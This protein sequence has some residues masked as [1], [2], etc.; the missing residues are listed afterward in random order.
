MIQV[1]TTNSLDPLGMKRISKEDMRTSV[2][3]AWRSDEQFLNRFFSSIKKPILFI[4]VGLN[5]TKLISEVIHLIHF[6]K[7]R[8]F[9]HHQKFSKILL[10]PDHY[11]AIETDT[12]DDFVNSIGGRDVPIDS[13]V[14]LYMGDVDSHLDIRDVYRPHP[15]ADLR[16]SCLT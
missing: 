16:C 1:G 11:W 4:S 10:Q 5:S 3:L 2:I 12:E 13:N 6:S 8:L 7:K 9:L 14:L 15:A